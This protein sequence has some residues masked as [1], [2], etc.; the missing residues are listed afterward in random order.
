MNAQTESLKPLKPSAASQMHQQ[1][2]KFNIYKIILGFPP[3]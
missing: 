2:T 1:H 3:C